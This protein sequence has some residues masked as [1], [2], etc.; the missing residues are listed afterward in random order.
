[1]NLNEKEAQE[2]LKHLNLEDELIT[3]VA[4]DVKDKEV[5]MVAFM[6][7]EAVIKTLTTGFVHY[8]SR[9]RNELWQKGEESGNHQKVKEVRIDCDGDAVLLDVDPEGPAC[10]KG[11]RSCFYRK[12]KDGELERIEE[13]EF[14]PD[15]VYG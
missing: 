12:V 9:S 5:L 8:W 13:R 2:I 7:K 15:E 11:F 6:N 10:H 4:R 1:M 14:D 3:A